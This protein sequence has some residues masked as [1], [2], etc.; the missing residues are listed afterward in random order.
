MNNINL[1][2]ILTGLVILAVLGLIVRAQVRARKAGHGCGMACASCP[3]CPS[4]RVDAQS[5]AA[6]VLENGHS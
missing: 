5:G 6:Q 3:G 2:T 1:P 4:T